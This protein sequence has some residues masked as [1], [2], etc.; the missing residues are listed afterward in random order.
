MIAI[1]GAVLRKEPPHR[2]SFEE[3]ALHASR[4]QKRFFDLVQL[5]AR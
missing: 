5:S 1:L 4:F 3:A 2:V